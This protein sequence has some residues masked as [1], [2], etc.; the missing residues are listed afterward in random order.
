[1]R[2]S[3]RSYHGSIA[4]FIFH[5]DPVDLENVIG[6]VKDVKPSVLI[7]EDDD[8]TSGPVQT[9]AKELPDCDDDYS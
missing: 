6:E 2:P 4:E 7:E 5:V 1:M 9:L 8:G 3:H